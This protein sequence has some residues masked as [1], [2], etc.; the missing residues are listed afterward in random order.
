MPRRRL[1]DTI[2]DD[3][4]PVPNEWTWLM[5]PFIKAFHLTPDVAASSD[6]YVDVELTSPSLLYLS[7]TIRATLRLGTKSED[8]KYNLDTMR[9]NRPILIV[10]EPGVGKT[11]W[12]LHFFCQELVERSHYSYYYDASCMLSSLVGGDEVDYMQHSLRRG[13]IEVMRRNC[14]ANGLTAP[15]FEVDSHA[16]GHYEIEDAIRDTA[17][18][19]RENGLHGWVVLDNLDRRPRKYQEYAI[20][21]AKHL[22]KNVGLNV[23]LAA[24]PYT[25][26]HTWANGDDLICVTVPPP[27]LYEIIRRRIEYVRNEPVCRRVCQDLMR[28][29]GAS[30]SWTHGLVHDEAT[31]AELWDRVAIALEELDELKQ[32]L[33]HV[34]LADLHEITR[35]LRELLSSGYFCTEMMRRLAGESRSSH[36]FLTAYFRGDYYHHRQS[37]HSG[38][39][40]VNLFDTPGSDSLHRLLAVR[41]L[42]VLRGYCRGRLSVSFGEL[43]DKLESFGYSYSAIR[44]TGSF[45]VQRRLILEIGSM[46]DWHD[47]YLVIGDSE[48]LVLS[49]SGQYY[50]DTLISNHRYIQ[51]MSDVTHLNDDIVSKMRQ[52]LRTAD[53]HFYNSYHL[54]NEVGD[55]VEKELRRLEKSQSLNAFFEAIETGDD[56]FYRAVSSCNRRA[57]EL[58]EGEKVSTVTA[59]LWVAL[60]AKADRIHRWKREVRKNS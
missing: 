30:L 8:I 6:C 31:L 3:K 11:T 52:V 59:R 26:Q 7:M 51:A 24:R 36:E 28:Q 55:A 20:E 43:R 18:L 45:L 1:I 27:S 16:S 9:A 48:E 19:L 22:S 2:Q 41:F 29:K 15:V 38:E 12:I 25:L 35:E 10:G 37:R 33:F 60:Q 21:C 14:H 4:V 32:L 39:W 57:Q 49:Q 50:L 54:L 40:I 47:P 13:L 5:D 44:S 34:H 58:L 17:G 23:L 53:D 56:F 42:Q 46:L